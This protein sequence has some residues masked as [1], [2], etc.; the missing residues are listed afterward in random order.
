MPFTFPIQLF[1]PS[2]IKP[3]L[4]ARVIESPDS[5]SGNSQVIR[6]DGGGYWRCDMGGMALLTSDQIRAHR[7]WED[8]MAGGVEQFIVPIA[9]IRHAPRGAVGTQLMRPGPLLATGS[10]PY[11]PEA[12]GYGVP[13]VI[14]T[15]GEAELRATQLSI[16]VSQ[17]SR[18]VGGQYFS[19]THTNKGRRMYRTGRVIAQTGQSATVN[20]VPPLREAIGPA[21][22]LDFDFPSFLATLAPN[23]DTAADL[24]FARSANVSFSFREAF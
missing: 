10:D 3:E 16:A 7:A 9:D 11:F 5:L 20:I 17:G 22:A 4:V 13:V 14:A 19:I 24:L 1:Q 12:L 8:H 23:T 21:T 18:I 2:Q 15:A 6:T